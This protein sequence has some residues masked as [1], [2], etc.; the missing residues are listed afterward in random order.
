MSELSKRIAE[1]TGQVAGKEATIQRV[2]D[3][4]KHLAD[5]AD[6]QAGVFFEAHGA[7]SAR[8]LWDLAKSMRTLVD[9]E[10]THDGA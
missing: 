2:R 10:E 6:R 5:R 3:E 8:V 7:P 4:L 9:G 1:L